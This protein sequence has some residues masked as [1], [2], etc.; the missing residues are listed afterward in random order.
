MSLILDPGKFAPPCFLPPLL[1]AG[2]I[3]TL[4]LKALAFFR[5]MLSERM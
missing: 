5:P 1:R 3:I 4:L 2:H